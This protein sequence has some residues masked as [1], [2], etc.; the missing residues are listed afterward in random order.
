MRSYIR[1][2]GTDENLMEK[3]IEQRPKTGVA[4]TFTKAH[5]KEML[6]LNNETLMP[7]GDAMSSYTAHIQ[8]RPRQGY[9]TYTFYDFVSQSASRST[10]VRRD[11]YGYKNVGSEE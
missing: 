2:V 5:D 8:G 6:R 7:E 1:K 3:L 10:S 11:T 9:Y 4:S